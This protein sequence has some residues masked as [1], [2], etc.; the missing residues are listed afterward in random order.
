[1]LLTGLGAALA[2]TGLS[3][4]VGVFV[5][6]RDTATASDP[7]ATATARTAS[8]PDGWRPWRTALRYDVKG[9][10]LDYDSTGCVAE[11]SAL[12][13]GGTGFTVGDAV[14]PLVPAHTAVRPGGERASR[15]GRRW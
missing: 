11:G 5:S 10:P 7:T 15:R 1:M 3:I 6:G 2:V 9:V 13:C 14:Q 4:G 8:L 12:F